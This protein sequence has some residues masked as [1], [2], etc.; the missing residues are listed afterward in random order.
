MHYRVTFNFDSAKC[1]HLPFLRHLS[2]M[3]KVYGL[4]QLIITV[5][6][7]VHNCTSSIDNYSPI[8]K[9]YSFITFSLLINA[10]I[11]LL[12]CLVLILVLILHLSSS[13]VGYGHLCYFVK[14]LKI[15]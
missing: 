14:I 9:F 7:L 5:Y 11:L 13:S 6:A 3:T 8:Y 2:L 12:K 10:V 4:L 1:V 15:Y